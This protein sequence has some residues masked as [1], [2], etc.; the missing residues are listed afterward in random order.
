MSKDERLR[1]AETGNETEQAAAVLS[2]I[3]EGEI[4]DAL[5]K[6]GQEKMIKIHK[7]LKAT[8]TREEKHIARALPHLHNEFGITEEADIKDLYKKI[9]INP[10]CFK[11]IHPDALKDK[12]EDVKNG[13]LH[14]LA[15]SGNIGAA[16]QNSDS[17]TKELILSGYE[18][19]IKETGFEKFAIQYPSTATYL[20][21]SAARGAGAIRDVIHLSEEETTKILTGAKT[22]TRRRGRR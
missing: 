22:R 12:N 4:E 15:K 1:M 7:R 2:C 8:G 5:D 16:L 17:E 18:E 21:N 13:L 6:I 20:A 14:E 11:N 19:E 9:A 3:K 10:E